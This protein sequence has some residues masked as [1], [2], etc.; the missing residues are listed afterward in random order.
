[1]NRVFDKYVVPLLIFCVAATVLSSLVLGSSCSGCVPNEFSGS[2]GL[3]DIYESV[4]GTV[5]T[6]STDLK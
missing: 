3:A 2:G 1:M 5:V 4:S 6:S